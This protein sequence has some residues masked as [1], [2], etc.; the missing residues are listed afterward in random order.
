MIGLAFI[1]LCLQPPLSR[2][3]LYGTLGLIILALTVSYIPFGSR[4]MNGAVVQLHPELEEAGHVAGSN[5]FTTLRRITL[6][7]LLPSFV[8]GW[9][10]I[11]SHS[12]RAFSLPLMLATRES[13]VISMV[14]WRMWD[15]GS[16]G[17]SAA[18]GVLLIM[19]LAFLTA[20]GRWSVN[21]L[22]RQ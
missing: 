14:L 15:D 17:Q 5:W 22:T 16:G 7:L 20:T 1:F 10:W 12:L 19:V 13:N 3:N 8:S 21:R 4:T 18:L 9:I 2:F 11:A 6:P